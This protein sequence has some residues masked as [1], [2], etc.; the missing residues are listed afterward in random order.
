MAILQQLL[1]AEIGSV[2]GGLP[3]PPPPIASGDPFILNLF[4]PG[5]LSLLPATPVY[6]FLQDVTFPKDSTYPWSGFHFAG[7]SATWT[8]DPPPGYFAV[9]DLV[10]SSVTGGPAGAGSGGS[11]EADLTP[12]Y[13]PGFFRA[14]PVNANG[15]PWETV[16][17]ADPTKLLFLAGESL[18]MIPVQNIG[19][20][21]DLSIQLVGTAV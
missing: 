1:L 11:I 12:Y 10:P 15:I 18:Y 20:M 4:F 21:R 3:P 6:T 16:H 2:G 7:S 17:Q 9:F 14:Q 19:S 13:G 8:G 5:A